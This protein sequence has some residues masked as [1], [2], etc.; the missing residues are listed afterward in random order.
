MRRNV[1]V[2]VISLGIVTAIL[3]ASGL[4]FS[5]LEDMRQ[6][7]NEGGMLPVHVVYEGAEQEETEIALQPGEFMEEKA[8]VLNES[9]KD[10]YVRVLLKIPQCD[11]VPLF[12]VGKVIN[13]Q[14]VTA[15]FN[16]MEQK[17][18]EEY[19]EK[20]G[21][22]LY[23]RNS[24]TAGLLKAG[25]QTAPLYEAVMLSKEMQGQE[26]AYLTEQS[27]VVAAEF[28]ETQWQE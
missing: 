16:G 2:F 26:L 10:V 13:R 4:T 7:E 9:T 12:K 3:T 18:E 28:S 25:K 8:S 19:W 21:E 1:R 27:I 14:F 22:Y 6:A 11:E 23:Y 15:V 17:Q 5:T 20:A 24:R